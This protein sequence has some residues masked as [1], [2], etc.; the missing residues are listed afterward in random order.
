MGVARVG[1]FFLLRIYIK[2]IFFFLS[3]GGGWLE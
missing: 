1:E 3:K 2:K